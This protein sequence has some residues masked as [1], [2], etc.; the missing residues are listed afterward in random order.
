MVELGDGSRGALRP[1]YCARRAWGLVWLYLSSICDLYLRKVVDRCT[2]SQSLSDGCGWVG[3][4][5]AWV[6]CG[7]S[8]RGDA[9]V[10]SVL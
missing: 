6:D 7:S 10:H 2:S 8:G 3:R 1:D 5:L 9:S 4:C